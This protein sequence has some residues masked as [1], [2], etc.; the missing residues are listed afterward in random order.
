MY[1][2]K[3]LKSTSALISIALLSG[4]FGISNAVADDEDVVLEEIVVTAQHREQSLK[5]V[6]ISVAVVSGDFMREH[7]IDKMASIR[8]SIL[9]P[10]PAPVNALVVVRKSGLREP[11]RARTGAPVR[12]QT[13]YFSSC[14]PAAR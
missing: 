13:A 9:L 1:N 3:H 11:A 6:P 4:A 12:I 5:D 8:I 7:S 2:F 14:A 10:P